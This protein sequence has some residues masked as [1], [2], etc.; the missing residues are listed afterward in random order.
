MVTGHGSAM[1]VREG[2]SFI[3]LNAGENAPPPRH[4]S[5]AWLKLWLSSPQVPLSLLL[6]QLGFWPSHDG[7]SHALA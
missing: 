1:E 2:G 7:L 4:L 3:S 5:T 6:S